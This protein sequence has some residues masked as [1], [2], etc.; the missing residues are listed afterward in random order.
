[1]DILQVEIKGFRGINET[2]IC[3]NRDTVLIGP[4]NCGKST[5]LDALALV[6]GRDHL[7]RDLTEHDFFG[8]T[9]SVT[10]RINIIVT[11]GNFSTNEPEEN[12]EWFREGRFVPK[13][14]STEVQQ[15]YA[16]KTKGAQLL[17]CQIGFCARF[18]IES[19]E[20][21]TI[22]YFHDSDDIEDPFDEEGIQRLTQ[23]IIKDIGFFLVP[24][25]RTWDK[26]FTFGSE[27]FRRVI[28][29]LGNVPAT[30]ILEA[31]DSL[32]T[33]FG[34]D[35]TPTFQ[36]IVANINAELKLL[37]PTEEK[38][39]FRL[40]STDSNSLLKSM[41]P[42]FSHGEQLPI[43][44]TKNGSGLLS[45]QIML[46]L[47]EFGKARIGAGKNFILAIE[48]PELHLPP[49]MQKRIIHRAHRAA[50]QLICTSH[51]SKIA[52]FFA[53][54]DIR[55]LDN[56]TGNLLCPPLIQKP[57][58]PD[59]SNHLRKLIYDCRLQL[60][61]GLLHPIAFITEGRIEYEWLNHF[62]R[63][64]ETSDDILGKGDNYSTFSA[65]LGIIP[66]EGANIVNTVTHL[67]PL[68][69]TICILVDGDSAGDQYITELIKLS[70]P[71]AVIIQWFKDKEIE[72]IVCDIML[73][74]EKSIL[75]SLN[76]ESHVKG[77][78][79][80]EIDSVENIRQMLKKATSS[81][82]LKGN[83]LA[84]DEIYSVFST[85]PECKNKIFHLL[86]CL[87]EIAAYKAI[88][89]NFEKDARS[90]TKTLVVKQK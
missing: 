68:K 33:N 69:N 76:K 3:F 43:P 40:T 21:E 86:E 18:D 64:T 28:N 12:T 29:T 34:F 55:V 82:G 8:S 4:N 87:K 19:L 22:R 14:W 63:L 16:S 42:H 5:I 25:S 7:V 84:Y 17:C 39:S 83:Y 50:N 20:V 56:Q 13:W 1:M 60:I 9:P 23:N 57:L 27:L 31:R 26:T 81:G 35:K 37:F 71:P 51:S 6:L 47:L 45:L 79:K 90:T 30:E 78:F 65:F 61:E 70:K 67:T 77:V 72:D 36:S 52:G 15:V 46:L 88:P 54:T 41:M 85:T 89:T 10:S 48:E 59:A 74:D 58:L 11:L 73:S 32:R 2:K 49:A 24:S 44:S 80:G 75:T 53:P 62:I 38:L 66:S